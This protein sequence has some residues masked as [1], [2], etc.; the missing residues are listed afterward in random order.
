MDSLQ[1]SPIK[2]DKNRNT[3]EIVSL[4]VGKNVMSIDDDWSGL[5]ALKSE[6]RSVSYFSIFEKKSMIDHTELY[7]FKDK[8]DKRKLLFAYTLQMTRKGVLSE[9]RVSNLF[10]I[11]ENM[12]GLFSIFFAFASLVVNFFGRP[13]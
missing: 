11:L 7:K 3:F 2:P 6:E 5:Q 10:E 13:C 12:G 1:W 8:A 9:Y 4:S